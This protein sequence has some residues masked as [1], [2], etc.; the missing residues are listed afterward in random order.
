MAEDFFSKI[1]YSSSNEDSAS[2]RKSLQINSDDVVLC[3]TGSGA[4]SLD[5]LIDS[6]AAIV[7][8][9]LNPAQNHLLELKMAAF[10][11]LSYEK[12]LG[13]LGIHQCDD[14]EAK[15]EKMRTKLS[16]SALA[17]WEANR[18]LIRKGVLFCGTWERLFRK[19]SKFAYFK[20]RKIRTLM[21]AQ[22]LQEQR[23]FW[24]KEWDNSSWRFFLRVLSSR[25]LWVN[26][27]REPGA[28]LIQKDFDVYQYMHQRMEYLATNYH[29][30]TNHYANL[31]FLGTYTEGCVL[32][33]HLRPENYACIRKNLNKI[34]I[35]T[36][37]LTEYLSKQEG[38][39]SKFSLSDVSSYAPEEAYAA[40]WK[41][42]IIAAKPNANF[43]ERFFLVKRNP[44]N[45][46]PEIQ[47]NT[48]LEAQLFK[49][50]E[51]AIYTFATGGI[52]KDRV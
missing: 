2:E 34:E 43:C 1:N 13:F 18:S 28:K 50:D 33:H 51:T 15:F 41:N 7:S 5:L 11:T 42:V 47:R 40:I 14:R 46:F 37:S 36:D 6:P 4:R 30:K 21:E 9:D 24:Y 3:I 32:P 38:R 39:F 52:V 45:A 17:F 16:P 19:M 48:P 31:M 12:L 25:F 29:L 10:E 8:I 49:E 23:E 44:E 35:V 27:V 22:T 20:R 26:L